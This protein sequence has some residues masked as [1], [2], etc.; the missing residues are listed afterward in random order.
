MK[1]FTKLPEQTAKIIGRKGKPFSIHRALK[2]ANPNFSERSFEYGRN[3]QRCVLAYELLRRGYNVT[4]RG[5]Y[6]EDTFIFEQNFEKSFSSIGIVSTA[7][8]REVSRNIRRMADKGNGRFAVSLF[9]KGKQEGHLFTVE[10]RNGRFYSYDAQEDTWSVFRDYL[11]RIDL[12]EARI[13][14][15]DNAVFNRR[16]ANAIKAGK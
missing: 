2:K 12:K 8:K 14:R 3:C 7:E 5:T 15:L 4:A 16:I 11:S 13:Y 1:D 9:G 10:L 6:A